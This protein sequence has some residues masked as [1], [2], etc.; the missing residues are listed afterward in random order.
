MPDPITH[1]RGGI[2]PGAGRKAGTGTYGEP[3]ESVRIPLSLLP[4]VKAWLAARLKSPP[5]EVRAFS[6]P[7][8]EQRHPLFSS[9]VPAGIPSNGDDH[10]DDSIDLNEHLIEHP[11]ATFFVRVQGDSMT[12]AGIADGDLLVVDRS[13]EPR[14][15]DIV[16]AAVNGDQTVKRLKPENP[17]FRPLEIGDGMDLVIWGVVAHAVHSF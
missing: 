15:G 2:R 13:R 9:K 4:I 8:R 14:S 7:L 17:A 3:T 11:G 1:K 5:P 10:S 12:G 16:V 6:A